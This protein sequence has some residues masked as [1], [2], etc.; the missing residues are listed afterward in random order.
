MSEHDDI[1]SHLFKVSAEGKIDDDAVKSI[2]T[3]NVFAGSDTTAISLRA[4]VHNL[5]SH[6]QSL[7]R[8]RAEM[9]ERKADGRLSFPARWAQVADWPF[10][11]ACISESLRLHPAVGMALPRV[12]P[13]GGRTVCGTFLPAEVSIY[14]VAS[15][16]ELT[17]GRRSWA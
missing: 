5:V 1:L 13:E 14:L 10:L 12:V 7:I 16:L 6:P 2:A 3:A 11:Q 9:Q 8:L 4:I 15:C 17:P